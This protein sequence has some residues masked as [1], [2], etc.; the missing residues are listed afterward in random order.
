[1]LEIAL[2][3]RAQPPA[4][5]EPALEL[6]GGVRVRGRI[7]R[8]D[9]HAGEAVVYDYKSSRAPAG[10]RWERDGTLQVALYMQAVQQLLGLRVVGGFYQPLSGEDLRPRGVLDAEATVELDVVGN[11]VLEHD[12]A[13]ALIE[14]AVGRAREAAAEAGR[15]ELAARPQTCAFRGGCMHPSIC[16]CGR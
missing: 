1:M 16:R 8:V 5:R 11:D 14:R 3:V 13:R 2:E 12:E 6:S 10:A 4:Q 7:D 9:A 15:G